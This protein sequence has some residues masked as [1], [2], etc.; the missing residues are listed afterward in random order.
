MLWWLL[1]LIL[2]A[3]SHLL[4]FTHHTYV[5]DLLGRVVPHVKRMTNRIRE[6]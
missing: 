6:L 2:S 5:K 1:W 3:T 4:R